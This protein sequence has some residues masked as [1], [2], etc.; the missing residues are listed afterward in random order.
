MK[1]I[2]LELSNGVLEEWNNNINNKRGTYEMFD[3]SNAFCMR[4]LESI[5]KDEKSITIRFNSKKRDKE[6]E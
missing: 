3:I 2:L 6:G 5:N 4:L 1:K